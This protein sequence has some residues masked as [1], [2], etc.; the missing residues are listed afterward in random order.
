MRYKTWKANAQTMTKQ[1]QNNVKLGHTSPKRC[2]TT[3]Q[4]SE[5][6]L[7]YTSYVWN[8]EKLPGHDCLRVCN[9]WKPTNR[10]NWTSGTDLKLSWALCNDVKLLG[11]AVC[12]QWQ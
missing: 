10:E 3:A 5:K 1:I 12:L 9:K 11:E 2:Q 8:D 6:T 4:E 7:N